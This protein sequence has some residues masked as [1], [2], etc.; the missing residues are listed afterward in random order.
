ME[1][2]DG[3]FFASS[4]GG[5]AVFEVQKGEQDDITALIG[6]TRNDE[7][8]P[9][10]AVFDE[11]VPSNFKDAYYRSEIAWVW[12]SGIKG[13]KAYTHPNLDGGRAVNS[14]NFTEGAAPKAE[15][16]LKSKVDHIWF[17]S[18]HIP[19]LELPC[20]KV[21]VFEDKTYLVEPDGGEM[22]QVLHDDWD[23]VLP[24]LI[25]P[26]SEFVSA[27][28]WRS[29]MGDM[30][31]Y[32]S[33][34]YSIVNADNVAGWDIRWTG[35][36]SDPLDDWYAGKDGTARYIAVLYNLLKGNPGITPWKFLRRNSYKDEV[37]DKLEVALN[38]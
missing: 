29:S 14:I 2:R 4:S 35:S 15:A 6:T 8:A 34:L 7:G 19:C 28:S 20:G 38:M 26:T 37:N 33:K 25:R 5:P 3:G 30:G 18:E 22:K 1:F 24:H 21:T 23:K 10:V 16:L 31:P 17:E 12:G 13:G 27:F 11:L 32:F 9:A 36:S